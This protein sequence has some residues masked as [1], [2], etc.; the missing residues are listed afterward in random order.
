M[1]RQVVDFLTPLI[2]VI[3]LEYRA[4]NYNNNTIIYK[5]F[6]G[7]CIFLSF[8]FDLKNA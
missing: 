5:L 1:P 4:Y 2:R 6:I 3:L 8:L 7:I